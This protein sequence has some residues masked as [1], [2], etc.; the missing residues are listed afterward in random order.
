ML[1]VSGLV[2]I[3]GPFLKAGAG[4]GVGGLRPGVG[5]GASPEGFGAV[6]GAA[7]AGLD[8]TG[9]RSGGVGDVPVGL[10]ARFGAGVG[11]QMSDLK[12]CHIHSYWKLQ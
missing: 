3:T 6:A 1:V 9:F 5:T 12:I 10:G 4:V 11:E 8:G 7:A 2:W